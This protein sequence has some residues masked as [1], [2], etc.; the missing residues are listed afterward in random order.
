[1]QEAFWKW[2]DFQGYAKM[3]IE[4][5]ARSKGL[6]V[7]K[8]SK[9][10]VVSASDKLVPYFNLTDSQVRKIQQ[11]KVIVNNRLLR[12]AS[13]RVESNTLRFRPEIDAREFYGVVC[14]EVGHLIYDTLLG[15]TGNLPDEKLVRRDVFNEWMFRESANEFLGRYLGFLEVGKNGLHKSTEK[16]LGKIRTYNEEEFLGQIEDEIKAFL[17][18][19]R[20]LHEISSEIYHAIGYG[21]AEQVYSKQGDLF[22]GTLKQSFSAATADIPRKVLE[23]AIESSGF[24]SKR[25]LESFLRIFEE[26]YE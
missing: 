21:L 11:V 14:E 4:D 12:E 2:W 25:T 9:K 10:I 1:M 6:S 7:G 16:Y 23:S 3:R 13:Y 15:E 20:D 19:A 5:Y 17:K 8:L 22:A 24:D 26:Y 18:D